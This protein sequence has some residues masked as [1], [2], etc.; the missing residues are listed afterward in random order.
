MPLAR[1]ERDPGG[2]I[3]VR[4]ADE[5]IRDRHEHVRTTAD[6]ERHADLA[7]AEERLMPG[8]RTT[9][10]RE[11]RRGQDERVFVTHGQANDSMT[12]TS[13]TSVVT[14][15]SATISSP[16]STCGATAVPRM[17]GSKCTARMPQLCAP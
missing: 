4:V 9:F 11:V 17:G 10:E 5:H 2:V 15:A 6:V 13:S 7:D 8:T 3:E 14:R 16:C 1:V 12:R